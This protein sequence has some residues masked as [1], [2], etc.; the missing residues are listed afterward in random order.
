MSTRTRYI[1]EPFDCLDS[2]F[3]A[4]TTLRALEWN[5]IEALKSFAVKASPLDTYLSISEEMGEGKC[6]I[7]VTS[8]PHSA[9][10]RKPNES[11]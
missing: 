9:R 6:W 3:E 4:I 2:G 5:F 7:C 10:A 8:P 11:F 1:S